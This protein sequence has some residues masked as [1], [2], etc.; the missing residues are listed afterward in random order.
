MH[1]LNKSLQGGSE[2]DGGRGRGERKSGRWIM[3]CFWLFWDPR[4]MNAQIAN[5][6]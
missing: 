2:T 6:D 4:L 3:E 5:L 1:A